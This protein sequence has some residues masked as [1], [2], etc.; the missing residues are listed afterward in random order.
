MYEA[1]VIDDAVDRL[2]KSI[3]P[4]ALRFTDEE[5]LTLAKRAR[6]SFRRRDKEPLERYGAHLSKIYEASIVSSTIQELEHINN[7]IG[8]EEK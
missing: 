7:A 1:R 5:V 6:E 8:Y 4:A 2:R 3:I